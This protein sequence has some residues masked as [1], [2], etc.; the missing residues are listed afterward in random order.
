MRAPIRQIERGFTLIELMIAMVL[1]LLIVGVVIM[2]FLTGNR[3][4]AQD[5]RFARLQENGRYVI[6]LLSEELSNTE[7]WGGMTT[8]SGAGDGVWS[9]DATPALLATDDCGV[10]YGVGRP[11]VVIGNASAGDASGAFDCIDAATFRA[12]T[13]VIL[14]QKVFGAPATPAGAGLPYPYDTSRVYLRTN[15]TNGTLIKT[16]AEPADITT[17]FAI[18]SQNWT[19]WEYT[20]QIYYIRDAGIP[21]LHRLSMAPD[22][23]MQDEALIEGIE[24]IHVMFGID[25]DSDGVANLFVSNPSAAQMAF[26]VTARIYVLV[27]SATKDH[28]HEDTKTYEFGDLCYNVGGTGGCNALTDASAPSEPQKYQRRV[29]TNTIMLRNPVY[30]VQLSS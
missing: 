23:S 30:R 20:P 19:Y 2:V 28:Q 16:G 25:T 26:A 11:T 5:E 13:T 24:A 9:T 21:T 15:T 18:P 29:F 8:G 1:G 7:F 12:G 4:Y 6:K 27:R 14:L 17:A 3:N 10:T 22:Y